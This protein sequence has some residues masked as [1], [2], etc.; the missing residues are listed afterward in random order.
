M[1]ARVGLCLYWGIW[2]TLS[3]ASP[4]TGPGRRLQAGAG[5]LPHLAG[6][7]PSD[8]ERSWN[9]AVWLGLGKEA[10]VHSASSEVA[11]PPL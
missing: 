9:R 8:G 7:P 2:A 10:I 1:D 3:L 11:L 4:V 5:E 6:A